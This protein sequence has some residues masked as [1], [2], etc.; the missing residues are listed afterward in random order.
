MAHHKTKPLQIQMVLTNQQSDTAPV[1]LTSPDPVTVTR[2]YTLNRQRALD[3]KLVNCLN[4]HLSYVMKSGRNLVLNF[5]TA[6]FEYFRMNLKE[7]LQKGAADAGLYVDTLE[8]A[9]LSGAIVESCYKVRNLK[10]DG[11]PGAQNRF[12]I[13]LYRTQSSVLVNGPKVDIFV[14]NFLKPIES[15]INENQDMLSQKNQQ[16]RGQLS[17]LATTSGSYGKGKK[18]VEG[19]SITSSYSSDSEPLENQ[20]ETLFK[21]SHCG[22]DVEDGIQ[23][24]DCQQWN[25]CSCEEV[26]DSL[27]EM[28]NLDAVSYSCLSCRQLNDED[29]ADTINSSL[30]DESM[31]RDIDAE[32]TETPHHQVPPLVL[33]NTDSAGAT[34]GPDEH[35]RGSSSTANVPITETLIAAESNTHTSNSTTSGHNKSSIQSIHEATNI[36]N[37]QRNPMQQKHSVAD[38]IN[39]SSEVFVEQTLDNG[40]DLTCEK[41]DPAGKKKKVNPTSRKVTKRDDTGEHLAHAK[42]VIYNLE[43]IVEDER[44]S[45]KILVEE[46]SLLKRM[47]S[48]QS[49]TKSN[50]FQSQTDNSSYGLSRNQN[51]QFPVHGDSRSPSCNVN[52]INH[53]HSSDPE[54]RLM[55]E[56]L[57]ILEIEQLKGR[58]SQL[59]QMSL[60]MSHNSLMMNDQLL[61]QLHNPFPMA[62]NVHPQ[63]TPVFPQWNGMNNLGYLNPQLSAYP[64][65]GMSQLNPVIPGPTMTTGFHGHIIHGVHVLPPM[66]QPMTAHP[67]PGFLAHMPRLQYPHGYQQT[68]AARPNHSARRQDPQ[69]T[70]TRATSGQQAHPD[71]RQYVRQPQR[72][73]TTE[74]PNPLYQNKPTMQPVQP[75]NTPTVPTDAQVPDDGSINGNQSVILVSSPGKVAQPC[76]S[77][78]NPTDVTDK[79]Y[80]NRENHSF[81]EYAA[82][83]VTEKEQSVDRQGYAPTPAQ[84]EVIQPSN[85][86][87]PPPSLF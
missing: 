31:M 83:R 54:L 14:D 70:N 69:P 66:T 77:K 71:P 38:G 78:S 58:I 24:D 2:G 85:G 65:L 50:C 43:K 48:S 45:N 56:R 68:N 59:E 86:N 75:L 73:C 74:I 63:L 82:T 64:H 1:K 76:S 67:P 42:S 55:R 16:I 51:E 5:S 17:L 44:S 11:T 33:P 22:E 29:E 13:N 84:G 3:K 37:H 36:Q 21:C 10:K 46:L 15:L 60:H 19:K 34:R 61:R 35:D 4:D 28:Y 6:A 62:T 32:D 8:N 40:V 53:M 12:T 18:M 23:C 25:H 26:S 87:P 81:E 39:P 9:D 20:E 7:L 79:T 27:L 41:P 52:G 57:S 30:L 72:S 80:T 49:Q 47:H